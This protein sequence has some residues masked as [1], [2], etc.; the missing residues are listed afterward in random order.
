MKGFLETYGVAIFT[1]VLMA[2]LIAMAGPFGVRIKEY[3]LEKANYTNQIGSEEIGKATN[4]EDK[5]DADVAAMNELYACLYTNGE[6]AL[7]AT[8]IDNTGR[9]DVT[10]DY[11]KFELKKFDPSINPNKNPYVP[12]YVDRGKVTTV[13]ILNKI[14]PITCNLWFEACTELTEIKNIK[15]LNTSACTEMVGMFDGCSSLTSLDA[16]HL[17]TSTCIDMQ[18]MFGYCVSL[19]SLDAS[20]WDTS[21][22]TDM[23]Q[24]FG[25]CSSLTSLDVSNWDTSACTNMSYMF[26]RCSALTSLDAS[27]WNTSA[28]TNMSHM[29]E[30]CSALTS[31][32][33]SSWD[34]S[35]CT[36]MS[37]MFEKCNNF[38]TLS[39]HDLGEFDCEKRL[40]YCRKNIF[41]MTNVKNDCGMFGIP[42]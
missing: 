21:A 10:N 29:F 26:E 25:F 37:Y 32:D 17:D 35:A 30:R 18:G 13:N 4:K 36:D 7:S 5:A 11:G 38:Q 40:D 39:G 22:C 15:N 2:I 12:W 24:M 31:L 6:L 23:S 27:N 19:T 9:T 1:L 8:P 34:T 14:N 3:M 41:D 33:T 28:C 16:S 42:M 20:S